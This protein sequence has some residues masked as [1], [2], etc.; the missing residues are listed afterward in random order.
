MIQIMAG[1]LPFFIVVALNHR[2]LKSLTSKLKPTI[3]IQ[4]FYETFC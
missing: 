2:I 1:W 4:N 3:E